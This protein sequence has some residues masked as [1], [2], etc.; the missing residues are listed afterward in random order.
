[1]KG[2]RYCNEPGKFEGELL[3]AKPLYQLSLEGGCN[4]EVGS[5][6]ED[7]CWYGLLRGPFYDIDEIEPGVP[8]TKEER[9][10]LDRIAGV[11]LCETDT[12]FVYVSYYEDPAELERAWEELL[13]EELDRVSEEL[14]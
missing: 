8:L 2:L 13:E 5:V 9:E 11:I 12:G 7:G 10:Y 1:M 4:D 14:L 3:I 6:V